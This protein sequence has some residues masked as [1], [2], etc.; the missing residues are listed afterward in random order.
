MAKN[1]V[2]NT[3]KGGA[4][5]ASIPDFM[6][7]VKGAGSNIDAS[8]LVIPRLKLI[9]ALSPEV[10]DGHKPGT[11]FHHIAEENVGD[12]LKIIPIYVFKSFMLWR[13]QDDGGGLLARAMD[14]VN[15]TPSEGEFKV[16]IN[17]GTKEVTWKLAKTVRESGLDQWGTED[18][19]NKQSP[20]AATKMINV[21]AWLP[22]FP[23]L[24]PCVITFQKGTLKPGTLFIS[25]L[26]L[27][28]APM[29]GQVFNLT[30][31]KTKN[32]AGQDYWTFKLTGDGLVQDAELFER[33]TDLNQTMAEQQANIVVQGAD[34]GAA[35]GGGSDAGVDA[36]TAARI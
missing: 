3:T 26:G 34:D 18:P 4:L 13:P 10:D 33:L 20:P 16:K 27:S 36:A 14:A 5:A 17:K 29:F 1:E 30:S 7:G 31:E 21:I 25:K 24:S 28:R 32:G 15:W 23:E 2:A 12:S 11:F 22:D 8:D 6:Q 35:E 9:Q 19:D